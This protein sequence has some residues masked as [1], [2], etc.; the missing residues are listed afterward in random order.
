MN[1]LISV[2]IT[3]SF[4]CVFGC[5]YSAENDYA[6]TVTNNSSVDVYVN[7]TLVK[8]GETV[9]IELSLSADDDDEFLKITSDDYPRVTMS[10]TNRSFHCYNY[11]IIDYADTYSYYDTTE[12]AVKT[13]TL[14]NKPVTIINKSAL[15]IKVKNPYFGAT[16]SESEYNDGVTVAGGATKSST[17]TDSSKTC[18]Y[19]YNDYT[20]FT[21]F[22]VNADGDELSEATVEKVEPILD[23]TNKDETDSEKR[24]GYGHITGYTVYV[25]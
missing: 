3:L 10:R 22:Y 15:S 13:K 1:K 16:Y 24:T 20:T 12:K 25:K 14:T 2:F 11:S 19:L 8:K 21:A 9:D 6:Q 17:E 4:L 18:P 5:S 23:T 7:E